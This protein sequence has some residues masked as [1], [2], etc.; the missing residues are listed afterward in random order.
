M[1]E[2]AKARRLF[3]DKWNAEKQKEAASQSKVS[4]I[5]S[6]SDPADSCLFPKFAHIGGEVSSLKD[7]VR[8]LQNDSKEFENI[9][10]KYREQLIKVKVAGFPYYDSNSFLS[11]TFLA[12]VGHGEQ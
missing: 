11:Y 6:P 2:V 7:Q 4:K 1:E 12:D 3:N 5:M 8:V 9:T 10:Q